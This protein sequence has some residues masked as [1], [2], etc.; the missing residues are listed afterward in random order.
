MTKQ[1]TRLKL[2]YDILDAS[3]N[4]TG[5]DDL[6]RHVLKK[7]NIQYGN[8]AFNYLHTLFD[9]GLISLSPLSWTQTMTITEKGKQYMYLFEMISF[10]LGDKL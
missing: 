4:M 7:A 8:K 6:V 1:R 3:S 9:A 10:L 2:F 5:K